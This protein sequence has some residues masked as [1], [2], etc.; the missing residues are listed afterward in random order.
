MAFRVYTIELS[1]EAARRL[2]ATKP[3]VYVGQTALPPSERLE[4]H[5]AGGPPSSR[6]VRHY[7]VRVMD[8][9]C[10]VTTRSAAEALER[11]TARKLKHAGYAVVGG[12]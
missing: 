5:L 9:S 3:V 1:A 11:A 2:R 6:W 12:H 10:A 4:H 7:G 8:V